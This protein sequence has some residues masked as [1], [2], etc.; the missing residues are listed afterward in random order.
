M[1]LA[2]LALAALFALTGCNTLKG[3]TAGLVS[4]GKTITG[5]LT[6]PLPAPAPAN[7]DANMNVKRMFPVPALEK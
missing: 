1:K 4:D 7:P 5:L 3:A 2:L 6:A